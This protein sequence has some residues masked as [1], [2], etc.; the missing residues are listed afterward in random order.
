MTWSLRLAASAQR[1]LEGLPAKVVSAV[2]EFML[3]PLL[4]EPH[5]VGKALT[6]EPTGYRAA[7][8]GPYRIVYRLDEEPR[9]VNVVRIDHRSRAYWPRLSLLSLAVSDPPATIAGRWLACV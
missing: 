3:G 6:R 7:R 2:V 4:K 9:T 8:R 5:R 1:S